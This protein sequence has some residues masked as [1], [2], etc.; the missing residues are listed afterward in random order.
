MNGPSFGVLLPVRT[1]NGSPLTSSGIDESESNP[2]AFFGLQT[3]IFSKLN[4][5]ESNGR[6][7]T[8]S[9]PELMARSGANA[10][11]TVGGS[12]PILGSDG[13][14]GTAVEF[15]D[16]GVRVEMTP[17]I[18]RNNEIV[19]NLKTEVSSIDASVTVL[20][21]P[22]I[23]KSEASTTINAR[24]GQTISIAGLLDITAGNDRA[25]VPW[26][27][28]VPVLGQLFKSQGK[29]F[30]KRELVFFI[31]PELISDRNAN[32]S[33]IHVRNEVKRLE[34]LQVPLD[35]DIK[36]PSFVTDILE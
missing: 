13:E 20:G 22:G 15:V 25:K 5:L 9:R 24:N 17:L 12:L 16:Y 29:T 3:A 35:R 4:F 6:A 2:R 26:L 8:L 27:G 23:K 1:N 7:K 32:N 34:S 10:S 28:D 11:F 33:A 31:T 21:V 14:G 19:I 18:N 30:S 36:G